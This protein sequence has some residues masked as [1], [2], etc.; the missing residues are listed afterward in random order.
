MKIFTT[1]LTLLFCLTL[2]SQGA[3]I[4]GNSNVSPTS[5]ETYSV[6]WGYWDYNYDNYANVTWNVIGGTILN[7]DDHSIT[8]QWNNLEGY[9]NFNGKISVSE[10]LGGQSTEFNII[11]I[12]N[13]ES[14]SSLC[15]GILGPKVVSIDF[16]SG[17]NPGPP[18]PFGTTTYNYNQSCTISP[19]QYTIVNNTIACRQNW[20][21]IPQDHTPND[22]DGYFLMVDANANRDE[23][24]RAVVT[25]LSSS[26]KYEFSAWVGNLTS[27]GEPP[28]I[29]FE[30]YDQNGNAIG[31][32]GS[33]TVPYQSQFQWQQVGFLFD[34]P[35]GV[36]SVQVVIVNSNTASVGNDLVFDDISFAACFPGIIA[37]FSNSGITDR[38]FTC[39]SG[40]VNLYGSWPST[41]PFQNP[42]FVWQRSTDNGISWNDIVGANN[43]THNVFEPTGGIIY[44]RLLSYETSNPSFSV[45]SNYIQ[46]FVQEL[47]VD[48]KTTNVFACATSEQLSGS[49]RLK[50][51]DPNS[52]QA[53]TF[54]WSPGNY[55]SATNSN[56]VYI[57]LPTLPPPNIAAPAPPPTL[58]NYTLT[59]TNTTFGCV[60]SAVQMVAHINPRKVYVPSAF[61]PNGDGSNDFFYPINIEDYPGAKFWVYNRWGNL[62]FYSQGP[63]NR[64]S[65]SWNGYINDPNCPNCNPQPSGTYVW[66]VSIPGCPTNVYSASNGNGVPHG[67]VVL[68]R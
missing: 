48:P 52:Q 11:I 45:I 40:S 6:T 44:Y 3:S 5:T 42:S 37:S 10:D 65:Y 19:G 14:G 36:T 57:S 29:R 28:K 54:A 56:S 35:A 51:S 25:G 7:S 33:I 68:I 46:Y 18:L 17:S 60:G 8:I 39:N 13:S 26:I 63:S 21:N 66:Q 16:G 24:Y 53:Y 15:N 50:Y 49:Y 20:H 2:Y 12:N 67:T 1:F 62:I 30:L 23:F 4:N 34:L 31:S 9:L 55:L 58:Y 47:E 32:S 22:V 38:T 61:T 43:L 59:V 41:I 27:L 64:A